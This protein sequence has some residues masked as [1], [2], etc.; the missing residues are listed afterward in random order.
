MSDAQL[1][2]ILAKQMPDEEKRARATWIITTD[3]LEHAR[4][5]VQVVID[6]IKQDIAHA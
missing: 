3:T 4:S 2:A 5:Q 1:D 6:S